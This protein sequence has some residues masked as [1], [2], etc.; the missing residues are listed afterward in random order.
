MRALGWAREEVSK[1]GVSETVI[2]DILPNSVEIE[3]DYRSTK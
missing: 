1:E 3:M 2:D